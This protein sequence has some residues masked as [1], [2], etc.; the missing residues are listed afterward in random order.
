MAVGYKSKTCSRL[1]ALPDNQGGCQKVRD[2]G[3]AMDISDYAFITKGIQVCNFGKGNDRFIVL[4]CTNCIYSE[5][6]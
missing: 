3:F 6:D 2:V 5:P 1:S 4:E